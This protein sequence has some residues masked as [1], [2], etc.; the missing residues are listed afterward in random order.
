MLT[1]VLAAHFSLYPQMQPQDAV[2]LIYQNEF[3]PGHMIAD[4]KKSLQR[5]LQE[6]SALSPR[7]GEPLYE[8]IGGGLCRLNLR[9]CLERGIPVEDINRLFLQAAQST[10][11]DQKR[12]Q[13]KLQELSRM[14]DRDETPFYAAEL[15]YFLILYKEKGYPAVHHSDAY[16]AAYAPAYRVVVQKHLK[17]YL[18]TLRKETKE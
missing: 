17:D 15:D 12:F 10:Q 5:L 7:K 4:E 13:K 3:G 14:A 1:E 18:K 8:A 11:G 16:R 9:P 6:L 2:K